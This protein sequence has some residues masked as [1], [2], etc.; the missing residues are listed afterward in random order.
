MCE[1]GSRKRKNRH[2]SPLENT[3]TVKAIFEKDD[4]DDSMSTS[5]WDLFIDEGVKVRLLSQYWLCK[6]FF[7]L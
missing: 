4:L 7:Y 5:D 6:I 2:N 1:S 3:K